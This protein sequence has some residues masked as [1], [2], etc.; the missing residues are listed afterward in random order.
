MHNITIQTERLLLRPLTVADAEEVFEWTGDERVTKYMCYNTYHSVE[1][2]AEWLKSTET[3]TK[4]Y[5]FGFVRTADR[6]LIGS[7]SIVPDEKRNGFW[8]FGYNFRHDCWGHGY[9]T[10]ATKAM[11]QYAY[12]NLGVRNFAAS[13]AEPN[14]ASGNVMEKCGLHFVGYG[15]FQKLDGSCKMRSMEYEVRLM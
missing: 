11:M 12:E 4:E 1:Q 14:R 2:V 3:D 10:E 8:K 15:E 5:L 13:H 9:A 6:K 7:G